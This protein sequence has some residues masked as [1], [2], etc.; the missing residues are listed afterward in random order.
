MNLAITIQKEC[1]STDFVSRDIH[2]L[3]HSAHFQLI[4]RELERTERTK[5][6][7]PYFS[8][9]FTIKLFV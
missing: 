4:I 9:N 3:G 2:F 5:R 8:F 7:F 6:V 1:D